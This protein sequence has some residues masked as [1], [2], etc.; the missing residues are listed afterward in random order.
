MENN[1]YPQAI[2]D[3]AKSVTI[4]TKVV[5]AGSRF[6]FAA[7]LVLEAFSLTR[8][9][10]ETHYQMGVAYAWSGWYIGL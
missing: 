4:K 5:P 8:S 9:L 3:L 1:N 6:Y 7:D 2:E 10:A